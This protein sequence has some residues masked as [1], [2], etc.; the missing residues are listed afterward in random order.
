[1]DIKNKFNKE[2][3]PLM[4]AGKYE[5]AERKLKL[6]YME[7]YNQ[8]N[9]IEEKRLI[10]YNLGWILAKQKRYDEAKFYLLELKNEMERDKFYIEEYENKYCNLLMLYI[11]VDRD[12]PKEE[13]YNNCKML[14]KYYK[15]IGAKEQELITAYNIAVIE[16][17]IFKINK[18]L[19]YIIEH[20]N[21]HFAR[22]EILSKVK[23]KEN[24]NDK[25]KYLFEKR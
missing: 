6:I 15:K 22:K 18:I 2:I 3:M 5:L 14:N 13:Y 16:K 19:K 4:D 1:M 20:K 9:K 11:E 7:R 25:K 24:K 23:E 10:T 8:L 17:N 21:L 12:I